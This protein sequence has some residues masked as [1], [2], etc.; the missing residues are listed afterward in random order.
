[1][2]FCR[3]DKISGKFV[4]EEVLPRVRELF[5]QGETSTSTPEDKINAN[6]VD[7]GEWEKLVPSDILWQQPNA[8]DVVFPEDRD[9]VGFG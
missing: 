7:N 2:P 9:Q 3:P 8:N 1:M 6:A 4:Y 5:W